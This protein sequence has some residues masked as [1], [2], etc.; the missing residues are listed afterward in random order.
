M[1]YVRSAARVLQLAAV[2]SILNMVN[3]VNFNYFLY[4]TVYVVTFWHATV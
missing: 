1:R 2:D 4:Y 3:S